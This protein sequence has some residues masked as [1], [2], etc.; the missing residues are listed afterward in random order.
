MKRPATALAR[1]R[2]SL[3]RGAVILAF[4]ATPFSAWAQTA[5]ISG[6]LG[7]FDVLNDTGMPAHGFEI[8][9]DGALPSDLYYTVPGGRY[10]NPSIVPYA[11]GVYV[12]YQS[13]Y[14]SSTGVYAATTPPSNTTNF[15][16][17]N[18]YLGGA[19]YASSGCEHLGQSMRAVPSTITVTGRWLVDDSNNPGNLIAVDPPAAIPSVYWFVA[20]PVTTTPAAPIVVA[21]AVAPIPAKPAQFGDAQWVKI[22]KTELSREV[23]GEELTSGNTSVVPEDPTQIETAWDILQTAP[24]TSNTRKNR[25][26]RNNQAAL[27]LTAGSVVRRYELYKYTGKYDPLTHEVQCADG[28]CTAPSAGELGAPLSAHNTASNVAPDSIVVT[29]SGSGAGSAS[30][31]G[32]GVNCG[33]TCASFATN[34]TTV[35]LTASAGSTIFTGWT[36]AC[37]GSQLTC[38]APISGK[39]TVTANFMLQYT[40][41]VGRSNPG[42][43]VA[44]PVGN[45]RALNC[46]GNCSA[47]FT[48]G[49]AVTLTATPPDGKLFVNWSGACSG[50]S[51]VCTLTITKDTSVQAVFSK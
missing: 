42:T 24:P 14:N 9:I 40:L 46:G 5:V 11:T 25:S 36:G 33:G 39:T 12:R 30:V 50:T 18:C 51:P 19:G 41:S 21:K 10:G 48:D 4:V 1:V 17:Q 34:G 2:G 6:F 28:T 27:S 22:F 45:D 29:K 47:K 16:W 3:T 49:T 37:T 44:S 8:K 13:S 43:V 26:S 35:T 32:P 31:S 38:N 7:A 20:P 23:T 15:S